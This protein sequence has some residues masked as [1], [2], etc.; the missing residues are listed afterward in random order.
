MLDNTKKGFVEE[1]I[2]S[3]SLS[4]IFAWIMLCFVY[5]NPR[6]SLAGN[7]LIAFV[8]AYVMFG[9]T[10]RIIRWAIVFKSPAYL[11]LLNLMAIV[12]IMMS[13]Q[14]LLEGLTLSNISL[15]V[16]LLSFVVVY[17]GYMVYLKKVGKFAKGTPPVRIRMLYT[18]MTRAQK[19][20]L[21]LP[22]RY[23]KFLETGDVKYLKGV[24]NED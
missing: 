15:A 4:I 10:L 16:F 1:L 22:D 7:M 23:I 12:L 2:I 19:I 8:P 24:N 14:T 6:Y 20:T 5:Y 18:A 21:I 13:I 3:L 17:Y 11:L 9:G